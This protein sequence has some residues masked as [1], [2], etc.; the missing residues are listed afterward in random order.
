MS[1]VKITPS[2]N[3]PLRVEGEIVLV[4]AE[5]REFGLGRRTSISLCRCGHSEK[6]PFCDGSHRKAGFESQVAAHDLPPMK[7][8]A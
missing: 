5:G 8:T 2:N 7:P 3:G 1:G 6:K 4:D